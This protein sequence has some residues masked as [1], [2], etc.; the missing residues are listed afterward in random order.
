MVKT[1]HDICLTCIQNRLGSIP[2]LEHGLPRIHKEIL[3]ERLSDHD[4]LTEDYFVFVQKH[5]LVDSLRHV[6]LYKNSQLTD[7]MLQTLGK[8]CPNLSKLRV[9]MCPQVTDVG[10]RSLTK[11]QKQLEVLEVRKLPHFTGKGLNQLKSPKLECLDLRGCNA[12]TTEAVVVVTTNNPSLTRIILQD[13]CRLT[14][15][16]F[17][18]VANILQDNLEELDKCPSPMSDE[19]VITLAKLCPNLKRLNLLGSS[20]LTGDS[21]LELSQGCTRLEWLDLSYC[22]GI[23]DSPNN[24]F[25]WILPTSLTHLSLCGVMLSDEDLLVDTLY[26]LWRLK[27]VR[28]CGIPALNDTTLSK[29]LEK[30]GG[31]LESVDIRGSHNITDDGLAAVAE[32]CVKLQKLDLSICRQ[33]TGR[34]LRPLLEDPKRAQLLTKVFIC[35]SKMDSD[36]LNLIAENCCNLEKIDA[37]GV[38]A[39]TDQFLVTIATHCHNLK[40]LGLKGCK[41]VTDF[42]LCEIAR[43]CSLKRLVLAGIHN[44]TDKTIFALANNCH[45]LTEIYLNGCSNVSSTTLNYLTDNSIERVYVEHK[46]PNLVPHHIMGKNLDTGEYCRMDLLLAQY[47]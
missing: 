23:Q 45:Y 3:L 10:I 33:V 4:C 41:Q 27:S 35:C 34:T 20:K 39:V 28:L 31:S 9:H 47:Q 40:L 7:E 17:S 32:Y 8:L 6:N 19:N 5:L 29:I 22:Y 46:T 12:L 2:D 30:L 42:G 16:V 21:L 11:P 18:A 14:P 1:L 37:S 26:R 13:C 38:E 15:Q 44:V 25:L 43:C 24:Q 36:V